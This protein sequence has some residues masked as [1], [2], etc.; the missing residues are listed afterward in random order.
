MTTFQFPLRLVYA[1]RKQHDFDAEAQQDDGPAAPPQALEAPEQDDQG[2]ENSKYGDD[3]HGHLEGG[4]DLE[5]EDFVDGKPGNGVS[6][7]ADEAS[8]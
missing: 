2:E 7:F 5:Y 1:Y 8:T 6:D 4:G 3:E